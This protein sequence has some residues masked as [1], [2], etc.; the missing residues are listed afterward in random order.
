MAV[1]GRLCHS[2]ACSRAVS[3]TA[4]DTWDQADVISDTRTP[5][6]TCG[7][8]PADEVAVYKVVMT[9]EFDGS[10]LSQL[11]TGTI[12]VSYAGIARPLPPPMPWEIVGD[13]QA[14]LRY[15]LR[16]AR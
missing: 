12:E 9:G 15:S 3:F 6:F 11:I 1:A 14:S 4:R 2:R 10:Q 5:W 16:R 7:S 13:Y 8:G